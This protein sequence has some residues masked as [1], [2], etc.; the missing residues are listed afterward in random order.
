VQNI[1]AVVH[2]AE[3]QGICTV[4]LVI[5]VALIEVELSKVENRVVSA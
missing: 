2:H 5:E 3:A 4:A 1:E